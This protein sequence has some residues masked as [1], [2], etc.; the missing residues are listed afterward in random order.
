MP[1][2]NAQRSRGIGRLNR[3]AT[4]GAGNLAVSV[5]RQDHPAMS[6]R[7]RRIDE[8]QRAG[9]RLKDEL[10]GELR[11]ARLSAGLRQR[12]VAR[13]L[14]CSHSRVGR[15]ERGAL[16]DISLVHAARHGAVVGLR[17]HARFYPAGGGL[18]DA[19]QVALLDRLRQRVGQAWH[20][21]LEA[22]VGLSG[23]LRAFDALLTSRLD[24]QV[25]VAVEAITRLRDAQ[26]QLRAATL[27]QRDGGVARLVIVIKASNANRRALREARGVLGIGL[28][29]ATRTVLARLAAGEDPG[30][31]GIALL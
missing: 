27:K 15:A 18:R 8:A 31:D 2:P 30:A 28:P 22:P 13:A 21:R 9:G 26:A 11:E 25:K 14:G 29:A 20:W 1:D 23:D 19:A 4:L 7:L 3:Q 10:G 12:D 24:P 5:A 17:L 6:N 16:R